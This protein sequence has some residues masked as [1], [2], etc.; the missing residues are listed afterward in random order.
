MTFARSSSPELR[1]NLLKRLF[2]DLTA[3]RSLVAMRD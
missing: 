2:F 3:A 1:G